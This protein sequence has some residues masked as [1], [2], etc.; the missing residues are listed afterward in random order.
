[1]ATAPGHEVER[2]ETAIVRIGGLLGLL[3]V[4]IALVVPFVLL[5]LPPGGGAA[6]ADPKTYLSDQAGRMA[7]VNG[8]RNLMFF[9]LLFFGAGLYTFTRRSA[10]LETNAWGVLGLLGATA[11][12]TMGTV[13]NGVETALFLNYGGVS[14]QREVFLVLWGVAG[15]LYV[16]PQVGTAAMAAGF[17]AAGWRSAALPKWLVAVGLTV[18]ATTL[19]TCIAIASVMTGG[20]AEKVQLVAVVLTL[21][22]LLCASVLMV[23][24]PGAEPGAAPP[25]ARAFP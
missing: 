15:V 18:A 14:E 11:A 12:A 19:L 1:M 6:P 20:W 7:I 2:R 8:L 16:V 10:P 5:A 22:W 25:V 9:C 23:W 4:G 24:R 13:A 17:S 3:I 21:L